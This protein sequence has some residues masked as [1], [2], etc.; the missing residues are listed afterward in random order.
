[1]KEHVFYI[2]RQQTQDLLVKFVEALDEPD[3]NPVLF[4][5]WGV[6]G[7]LGKHLY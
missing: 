5:I 2:S 3:S 1:M 6:S 4:N 7:I